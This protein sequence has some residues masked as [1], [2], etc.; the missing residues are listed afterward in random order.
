MSSI[1]QLIVLAMVVAC[2]PILGSVALGQRQK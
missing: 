2:A 1:V